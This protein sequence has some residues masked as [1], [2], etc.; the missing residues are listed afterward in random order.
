MSADF[1]TAV[2][3]LHLPT[4]R[5]LEGELERRVSDRIAEL[6]VQESDRAQWLVAEQ[7][8]WEET[9]A[10][11]NIFRT[12]IQGALF[13]AKHDPASVYLSGAV[14]GAEI[15][16]VAPILA[17]EY[18]GL[19][20]RMM[21]DHYFSFEQ[22][23]QLLS[24]SG[25]I[26][27]LRMLD[28]MSASE[29]ARWMAAADSRFALDWRAVQTILDRTDIKPT[30]SAA[31][32]EAVFSEDAAAE[33][34]MFG[35]QSEDEAIAEIGRAAR[36]LGVEG[37]EEA[38]IRTV[39]SGHEPY[40]HILHYQLSIQARFDHALSYL[41][42]FSPRGVASRWL[43]D[44]YERAGF[45]VGGNPFLNNAK[46]VDQADANWVASKEANKKEAKALSAILLGLETLGASAKSE[47][48]MILRRFLCRC[49]RMRRQISEGLASRLP[50]VDATQIAVLL[51][52]VAARNTQTYG[53][54]EQRVLEAL[55]EAE[56]PD[57]KYLGVGDSVF[58]TNTHRKKLGDFERRNFN[59]ASPSIY[60]Y[61]AHGGRL[62]QH[63][64]NDH[65]RSYVKVLMSRV[66]D[67]ETV[68]D[69]EKWTL[70]IVFVSHSFEADLAGTREVMVAPGRS[71]SIVIV[72]ETYAEVISRADGDLTIIW[73]SRVTDR[74]NTPQVPARFRQQALTLMGLA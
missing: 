61:E 15:E 21:D 68:A 19:H 1:Q 35:D 69:I 62:T 73:N 11:S 24:Y 32:V 23:R 9:G 6:G 66:E 26:I 59:P 12:L 20:R 65:L 43:I 39:I 60:A 10:P 16:A 17:R 8:E 53:I 14:S 54:L 40:L 48:S 56:T 64:V 38:D 34:V 2:R 29:I 74:M 7:R 51:G 45:E 44:V 3:G 30:L 50:N 4:A 71:L 41:Y 18:F 57:A 49:V 67:M 37:F 22:A 46:A 27:R 28:R 70:K 25:M 13:D 52:S 5:G 47:L 31:D 42:E 58:A 36:T 63:Y 55:I 33:T 72:T